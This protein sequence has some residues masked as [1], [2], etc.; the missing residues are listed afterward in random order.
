MR[1]RESEREIGRAGVFLQNKWSG[2]L[3]GALKAFL[4]AE[5][6]LTLL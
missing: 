2:S 1:E 3:P 5:P 4:G 6:N